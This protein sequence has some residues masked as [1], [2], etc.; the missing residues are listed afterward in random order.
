VTVS[1]DEAGSSEGLR[2]CPRCEWYI[3]EVEDRAY[4][5]RNAT[6]VPKYRAIFLQ[7]A[8]RLGFWDRGSFAAPL[9]TSY[10]KELRLSG[11]LVEFSDGGGPTGAPSLK[12]FAAQRPGAN[13]LSKM[14]FVDAPIDTTAFT[15]R[16]QC[17]EC[18]IDW[19][20][21]TINQRLL[22]LTSAIAARM[23]GK[24]REPIMPLLSMMEGTGKEATS[25]A[26][27][28]FREMPF[29]WYQ[30]I[31]A[32]FVVTH[33]Q[34]HVEM[35]NAAGGGPKLARRELELLCDGTACMK[36]LIAAWENVPGVSFDQARQIIEGIVAFLMATRIVAHNRSWKVDAPEYGGYPTADERIHKVLGFWETCAAELKLGAQVQDLVA[37]LKERTVEVRDNFQRE[38][39]EC[40]ARLA[41][42]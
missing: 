36:M 38:I 7:T 35:T 22:L 17:K 21:I 6:R 12:R 4:L 37:E 10:R 29:Y 27:D 39:E 33:E 16:T 30:A 20:M 8:L 42:G 28:L 14:T 19:S 11:V 2:A 40:A 1:E 13:R 24:N 41:K 23:F 9:V 31:A 34:A 15:D 5:I 32:V 25:K 3:E 18:S 26:D